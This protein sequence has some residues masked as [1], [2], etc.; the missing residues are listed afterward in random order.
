MDDIDTK[1]YDRID[2]ANDEK[3]N[4]GEV[5]LIRSGAETTAG[6]NVEAGPAPA[7]VHFFGSYFF[8]SLMAHKFKSILAVSPQSESVA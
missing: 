5:E 1:A 7:P 6:N 4:G 2:R 3:T 8:G